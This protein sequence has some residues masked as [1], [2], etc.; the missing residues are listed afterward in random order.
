MTDVFLTGS[1]EAAIRITAVAGLVGVVLL[2]LRVRDSGVRHAAWT[3]VLAAMLLMPLL[4][5]LVPALPV[6]LPTTPAALERFGG[7]PR[8]LLV[9]PP[10]APVNSAPATDGAASIPVPLAPAQAPAAPRPPFPWRST[11]GATS[12]ST[13]TYTAFPTASGGCGR[14]TPSKQNRRSTRRRRNAGGR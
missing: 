2:V 6:D 11:A 12:A 1:F 3:A 8:L 4:P 10:A 13:S 5:A 14:G 7:E 9:E